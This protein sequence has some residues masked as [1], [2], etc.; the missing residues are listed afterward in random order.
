MK[1][2]DKGFM[3]AADL[4][5]AE[6]Y[7]DLGIMTQEDFKRICETMRGDNRFYMSKYNFEYHKT[8]KTLRQ[9]RYDGALPQ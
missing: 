3:T 4:L 2:F 5:K 6:K 1:H 8:V 9:N 7:L